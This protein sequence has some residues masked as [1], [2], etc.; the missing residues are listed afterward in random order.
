[1]KPRKLWVTMLA[2]AVCVLA[3]HGAAAQQDEL[4]PFGTGDIAA[5]EKLLGLEFT[6][7]E[8]DSMLGDL[9]EQLEAYTTLHDLALPNDV[10]PALVFD[11]LAIGAS[12]TGSDNPPRWS[13]PGPVVRP[14][15]LAA[16]AYWPIGRLAALIESGGVTSVELTRM[17][18][19]RLKE[20]DARLEC[21][22]TLLEESAL[23]EAADR[24]AE[25]AAGRC[26]GPLHGIPCGVKD[27][28]AVA[29]APTTWGAAP[30]RDQTIDDTATVVAKLREAGVVVAAKLTLGALA[31]GDVWFDGRTRNPWRLE[32]G[33]SGSSAGPASAV[34]AGLLPFA[35]GTETWGSIVSPSTRC[36]VTGLRPTFGA[37][38]RAGAMAL[39]WS[40]DKI[41]PIGRTVE[42]CALVFDAIRGADPRDP[43]TVDRAF[44]YDPAVDL[45]ALKIGFDESAFAADYPGRDLDLAALDVL[46]SLGAEPV[47]VDPPDEGVMDLAFILSAE[48]AAAFSELTLSGRDDLLVRQTRNAWPNVFRAAR[49]IPAVEYIDANRER[50]RVMRRMAA[51]M[52]EVDVYVTPSFGGNNL[53]LTNLTGHPCVVVPDGF[54]EPDQPHSLSFIGRLH[55]EATLLAVAK[56]YQDATDFHRRRPPGFRAGGDQ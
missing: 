6:A 35:I 37:V 55:G 32:Q 26:R 31:W 39:S 17:Y 20:N 51:M 54:T 2:A 48:A 16:V 47:A 27:L 44:A 1:M 8:R 34:A 52:A 41:G 24:D 29:G 10:V 22:V 28:L 21:V 7:A 40:M 45:A 4:P 50:M 18:L 30:Y 19:D 38:S 36:G 9:A 12:A 43:S 53:L 23:A 11:P 56:A 46:R 49:F 14:D 5:A 15:D 3:P 13:D 25:L 42:D 33:S